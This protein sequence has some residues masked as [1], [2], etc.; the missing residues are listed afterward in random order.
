M[1]VIS[2]SYHMDV[3]RYTQKGGVTDS[4]SH[5]LVC[6][7]TGLESRAKTLNMK[8]LDMQLYILP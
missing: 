3:E 8:G 5:N 2:F 1:C 7:E 6:G 4:Q